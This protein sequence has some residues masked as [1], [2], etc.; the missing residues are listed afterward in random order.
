MSRYTNGAGQ[1]NRRF[2]RC[3]SSARSAPHHAQ[4]SQAN[5]PSAPNQS[6][7]PQQIIQPFK[8]ATSAIKIDNGIEN[9]RSRASKNAPTARTKRCVME[10]AAACWGNVREN[11]QMS[12]TPAFTKSEKVPNASVP[13][14]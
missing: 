8:D 7:A 3:L 11:F 9:R 1:R 13:K 2:V 14:F 6:V 5:A 12:T 4:G 10:R